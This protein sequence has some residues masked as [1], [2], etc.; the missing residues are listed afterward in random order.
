MSQ[1]EII[2]LALVLG[3]FTTFAVAV[4]YACFAEW[5]FEAKKK[6]KN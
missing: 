5:R 6:Q 1:N 3:A 2:F 4:G